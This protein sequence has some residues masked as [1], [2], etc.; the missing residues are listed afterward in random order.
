MEAFGNTDG[1]GQADSMTS[2]DR[3]MRQI[4]HVIRQYQIQSP[5]HFELEIEVQEVERPYRHEELRKPKAS[6]WAIDVLFQGFTS[7]GRVT[8]SAQCYLRRCRRRSQ[9]TTWE[10]LVMSPDQNKETLD[11]FLSYNF[12][13]V[14]APLRPD[15]LW[16]WWLSNGKSFNWSAL[17]TELKER[18]IE[19]CMHQ[20]HTHG[21]YSERLGRFRW[22]YKADRKIRRPGPFEIIDQ[23]SDWFHLLYVSHQVRAI[24]LRLCITGGSS[25]THS[26]GLC[27]TASSCKS[28]TERIDRLGQYYQ[29]TT[30]SSI[31]TCPAEEALSKTY[32]RFPKI[33]P[34]LSRYAT[35]RHGIQK[36]SICMDFLSFMQFF[37]V[38]AGGF[39]RYHKTK[40][41][42]Y[43]VFE[44]LPC[45]N[46]IVVRLP[47]RPQGGWKHRPQAGGPQLWHEDYPCPRVLHRIIYERI[48]EVLAPYKVTVRNF[49]DK[50]EK[51]RYHSAKLK[52][53]K[54]LRF[55]KVD[56]E[57]MYAEDDGGV[58][59]L[60]NEKERSLELTKVKHE[61]TEV[62]YPEDMHDEFF[63]P[64][65]HCNEPCILA[66]VLVV[67]EHHP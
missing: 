37:K 41:Y 61:S 19:H 32:G 2:E 27:I 34:R 4:R 65:C 9:K 49:L 57:E 44:R 30:P 21:I 6:R 40:G 26:N 43:E 66:P 29:M 50:G 38:M 58:E 33:Y 23:L 51:Q 22:R 15:T 8:I 67:S 60:E 7:E 11:D 14:D 59:L 10:S 36:I 5:A 47:L 52:A 46:E 63:P 28:F 42:T 25:L 48:A 1:D 20:P 56:L 53:V 31:P 45:L 17:P 54:A 13:V 62:E 35:L 64:L 18:I 3:A 16:H 39:Q 24:T 12:P 55:A